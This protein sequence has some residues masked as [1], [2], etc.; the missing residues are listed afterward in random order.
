[1]TLAKAGRSVIVPGTDQNFDRR[2]DPT[3]IS[4]AKAV[5]IPQAIYMENVLPTPDGFQSVGLKPQTGI[6]TP[7][8]IKALQQVYFA[9][10][11]TTISSNPVLT[12]LEDG[13]TP[14]A[15]IFTSVSG[16]GI[17]YAAAL[18]DAGTG[19]LT[20]AGG[21][22]YGEAGVSSAVGNPL[23]AFRLSCI[24]G[25][26]TDENGWSVI[27]RDLQASLSTTITFVADIYFVSGTSTGSAPFNRYIDFG[28]GVDTQGQGP[29]IVYS[30]LGNGGS[31]QFYLGAAID[32]Q[33]SDLDN[34]GTTQNLVRL[35]DGVVTTPLA[36]T[37]RSI[38]ATIKNAAL[39]VFAT[40][41]GI[42]TSSLIT[43]G[44]FIGFNGQTKIIGPWMTSGDTVAPDKIY[45]DNI[46]IDQDIVVSS[47]TI[48]SG[49][50]T[51]Y[52]AYHSDNT[53]TWSYDLDSWDNNPVT[54]GT[55]TSPLTDSEVSFGLARGQGFI[56]VRTGGNTKIYELSITGGTTLVF[57]D[58][59]AA[60]VATLSGFVANDI[61]GITSSYNY[62]ILYT[63]S[64]ILWSSTTTPTDF[65]VSLVSGAGSEVPG[66][67]K[68][69]ITFCREHLAGFF[70]YTTKNAIFAVYT[71]N[72]RYPWK[73]REVGGSSGYTYSTQIAGS[74]NAES[75]YGLTNSKYIQELVPASAGLI[76]PEVTDFLSTQTHWD[77]FD[78]ATNTF[79][80][81][82]TGTL[83]DSTQ[84]RIWFVLDRYVIVPYGFVSG[85][86]TYALIYDVLLRRYGKLKATFNAIA[87]DDVDF[88][89]VDYAT[90]A[91]NKVYFDIYDQVITGGGQYKHSGV[92]LLGKFQFV[93]S[94]L[95]QL[96]E[97][98]IESTQSTTVL[99]APTDQQFSVFILPSLNG[100]N[101]STPVIPYT[102]LNSSGPWNHYLAPSIVGINHSIGLKG[103]FDVNTIQL[104]FTLHGQE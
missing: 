43:R 12:T 104:A 87:T 95:L 93:R 33:S 60:I 71:G 26:P 97:I 10:T 80:V 57:T 16:Q 100:K 83:L 8:T 82:S 56:C 58:R 67:L 1:M 17:S 14:S 63:A 38:T 61:L 40:L 74:T 84:P 24:R 92:L 59:T 64:T 15:W 35:N 53:A 4:N 78:S 75:Q 45:I 81:S 21:S 90:G 13:T 42:V 50:R 37:T 54:E 101:F 46:R 49:V 28:I 47:N 34:W 77:I 3:G 65:A 69:D 7:G 96:D 39:T 73:F 20:Y 32:D 102:D 94:R 51:L 68:G 11:T 31:S 5:G 99:P 9:T 6:T 22:T 89:T 72:S 41:T 27:R 86:Y 23:P 76:A 66:N 79:S 44:D 29:R 103:A 52:I 91:I 2:I 25:N 19:T 70:I 36:Y 62:L 88:Y 85:K 55:F 48:F 30:D 18:E 98:E